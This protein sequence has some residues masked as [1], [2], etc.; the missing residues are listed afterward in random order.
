MT[1]STKSSRNPRRSFTKRWDVLSSILVTSRSYEI[2][3][4]HKCITLEFD[5]IFGSNAALMSVKFQSD[6]AT[7][8]PKIAVSRLREILV[9]CGLVNGCLGFSAHWVCHVWLERHLTWRTRSSR[10]ERSSRSLRT[11]HYSGKNPGTEIVCGRPF[12]QLFLKQFC[13]VLIAG[14]LLDSY[15]FDCYIYNYI[16]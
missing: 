12:P 14:C 2:G 10:A 5:R 4:W 7:L 11:W 3:V 9:S 16:F 1:R 15:V 13:C 8:N 6:R